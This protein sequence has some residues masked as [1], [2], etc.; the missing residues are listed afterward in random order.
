VDL[1]GVLPLILVFVDTFATV[2]LLLY[3][4]N[5]LNRRRHTG[6]KLSA[7]KLVVQKEPRSVRVVISRRRLWLNLKIWGLSGLA[8]ML[9]FIVGFLSTVHF[10]LLGEIIPLSLE[11]FVALGVILALVPPSVFYQLDS[12][13]KD[14]IDNNLPVMLQD[15][16]EA[17]SL[18]MTI[19]RALEVSA[20]RNYG[21]LTKE[22]KR[23]VA[24]L[25]WKVSF[26]KALASFAERC[27]TPLARYVASLIQIAYKS[28]GDVQE[29]IETINIHVQE[30]QSQEMK[31]KL[32]M[33]PQ[34]GVIYLSFAIFIVTVYFLSTQF[35][36]VSIGGLGLTSV[37]STIGGFRNPA[38]SKEVLMPIFFYMA[39]VEGVFSGLAGGKISTGSIKNG[40][41]HSVILCL[42]GFIVFSII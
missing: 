12:R 16:A 41:I 35:F 24:Q 9:T 36:S 6:V 28:G 25:S 8:L 3:C 7:D 38:A 37:G 23:M 31:R 20:E 13:H 42:V 14:A 33:R 4:L 19:I 21:Y 29:S 40:F 34:I 1:V 22:L 17:G 5:L 2:F 27:G 30:L 39:M 18:G 32:E 26:D 10:P 11:R 15:V